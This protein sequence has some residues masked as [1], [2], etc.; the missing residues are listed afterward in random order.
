MKKFLKT[1]LFLNIVSMASFTTACTFNGGGS[2]DP[3]PTPPIPKPHD[4]KYWQTLKKQD[5]SFSSDCDSMLQ[6]IKSNKD[7]YDN[8]EQYQCALD[9]VTAEKYL[10]QASINNCDYQILLLEKITNFTPEQKVLAIKT[11]QT[12]IMNLNHE[13]ILKQKYPYDYSKTELSILT[14][15]I[16]DTQTILN[17]LLK[18]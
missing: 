18:P 5:I 14:K 7:Q 10:Y 8:Q 16:N 6:E 15:Q 4:I 17:Q 3:T 1:F 2:S 11:L 13:L 9:E 12:E